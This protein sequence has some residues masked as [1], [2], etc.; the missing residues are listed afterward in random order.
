MNP[1]LRPG[2]ALT[3]RPSGGAEVD[4]EN[5]NRRKDIAIS[6]VFFWKYVVK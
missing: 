2:P 1:D 5:E 3:D 6:G 4:E